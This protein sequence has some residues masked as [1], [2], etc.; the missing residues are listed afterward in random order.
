MGHVLCADIGN[1]NITIGVFEGEKIS[2]KGKV[3][4]HSYYQYEKGI[5]SLLGGCGLGAGDIDRVII[6]SVVPLA[7][8]RFVVSV[9]KLMKVKINIVGRDVKAPIKNLY[10]MKNE[11]GQDRLVNA[12]AAKLIYGYPGV[13]I[14]FGTAITFDVVSKK[15]EYLGGLILPGIEM[16]LQSLYKRTALLPRVELKL[17]KSIIGT[18]TESS[19]QGGILF[20]YGA[21]CDGLIAKYRKMLGK[22]LSVIVTGGNAKLIKLYSKSIQV[23]DEDLTLKGLY[24]IAETN[25]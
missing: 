5:K 12:F 14:D 16:G 18:D 23:V 22:D 15:G 19:M 25:S 20:G 10:R 17:A 2:A 24:H 13:I 8:A 7:L 11:V 4:T 1:T 9:N 6:S 21:M 3:S